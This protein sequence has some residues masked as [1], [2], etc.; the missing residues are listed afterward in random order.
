MLLLTS[1]S[2]KLLLIY[3]LAF[4]IY[5]ILM[6]YIIAIML[7]FM[8]SLVSVVILLASELRSFYTQPET[9]CTLEVN[10]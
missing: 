9:H 10:L 6:L 5:H 8:Y 1:K 4:Y 3:K 7:Y 2:I